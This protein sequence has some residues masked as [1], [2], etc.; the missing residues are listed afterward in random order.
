MYMYAIFI[1]RYMK[2]WIH[3]H[4]RAKCGRC[5]AGLLDCFMQAFGLL[6]TRG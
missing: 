3:G 6:G 4:P 1:F 5:V 2:I